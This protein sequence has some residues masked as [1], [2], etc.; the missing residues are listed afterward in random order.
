MRAGTYIPGKYN[1]LRE[2]RPVCMRKLIFRRARSLNRLMTVKI[3]FKN[4]NN[5][6]DIINYI[7]HE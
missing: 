7:L 6:E 3:K 4:L 1:F 5:W 2:G